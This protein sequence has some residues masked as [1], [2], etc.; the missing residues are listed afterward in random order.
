[1]SPKPAAH[2]HVSH[3]LVTTT[4]SDLSAV[5]PATPLRSDHDDRTSISSPFYLRYQKSHGVKT[6][7]EQ[8]HYQPLNSDRLSR[9]LELLTAKH[10]EDPI[11]CRLIEM[12]LDVDALNR[13][14]SD[15]SS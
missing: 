14:K 15:D 6:M 8:Y 12:L 10:H 5:S 3:A 1:A 13:S 11:Q 7:R 2:C 4:S 9:V